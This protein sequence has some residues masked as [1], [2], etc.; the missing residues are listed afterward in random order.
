[1]FEMDNVDVLLDT[2]SF[3]M[4]YIGNA[5]E[6]AD[7]EV[8]DKYKDA[9]VF[10][11]DDLKK[12]CKEKP[13]QQVKVSGNCKITC[14]DTDSFTMAHKIYSELAADDEAEYNKPKCL[15]MN[16]ANPYRPGGGVRNGAKAQEE[17]LCRRSSLLFSLESEEAEEYYRYNKEHSEKDFFGNE[18]GTNSLIITPIVSVIKNKQYVHERECAQVAV[19]TVAAPIIRNKLFLDDSYFDLMYERIQS[20][21]YCAAHYGYTHLVLGAWGCGAFKNDPET[22][23]EIFKDVIENFCYDGKNIH[24]LFEQIT[25]AVPYSERRPDNYQAFHKR[26]GGTR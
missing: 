24:Q 15:V 19:L 5:V 18:Y 4:E 1:M 17:D 7:V 20:V 21:L 11:P 22:V 9:L 10:L 14:E 26:F 16:F 2:L 23:S 3:F 6:G 8:M 12:L 13:K 25:F